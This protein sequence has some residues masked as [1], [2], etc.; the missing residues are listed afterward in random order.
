MTLRTYALALMLLYCASPL[1][2]D[3]ILSDDTEDYYLPPEEP[4]KEEKTA[5][6]AKIDME[7]L[8]A[9]QVNANDPRFQ[10][11]IERGSL[12]TGGDRVT[13]FVVVIRSG[14][15]AT[16]TSYEAFRCGERQFKVYAYGSDDKLFAVNEPQ[17]Q[18]VPK[19]ELS[20]Y[21]AALYDDLICNL[22]TGRSNPP[23][24]V[25]RAMGENRT[26][27]SD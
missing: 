12:Q 2:A 18:T 16:N 26:L 3:N 13:R 17:W 4:F 6:P 5:L 7:D 19:D 1:L 9:F 25:F 22:L 15:G 23:E 10:F 21:R 11:F 27:A 24:A 8:Q 20:D 14:S